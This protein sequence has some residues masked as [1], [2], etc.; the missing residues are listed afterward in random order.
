MAK[1]YQLLSREHVASV[2]DVQ[3]NPSKALRGITRVTRGSKTVG[4]FFSNEEFD[5]LLEDLEA[6][7]S[8]AL[9][10]RVREARAGLKAGEAVSLKA[11]AAKYGI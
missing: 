3:K 4:F 2:R 6:A 1:A 8:K 9:R 11:V 10:S 7:G 5:E